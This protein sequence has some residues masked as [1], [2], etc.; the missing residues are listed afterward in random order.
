MAGALSDSRKHRVSHI[1]SIRIKPSVQEQRHRRTHAIVTTL[2][3][4]EP[5]ELGILESLRKPV[6][7]TRDAH[8]IFNF[9][10]A[11][12]SERYMALV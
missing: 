7:A 2:A 11:S 3:S 9:H 8:G 1:G 5:I 6:M 12:F 10:I 4:C